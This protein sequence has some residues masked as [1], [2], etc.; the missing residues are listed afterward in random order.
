MIC[1]P[2]EIEKLILSIKHVINENEPNFSEI[3]DI[4]SSGVFIMLI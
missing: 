4:F 2:P 3:K 1:P